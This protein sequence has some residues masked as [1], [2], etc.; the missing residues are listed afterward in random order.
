MN[1]SNIR[2][3]LLAYLEGELLPRYDA[4]DAAHRRDH[5]LAVAERSMNLAAH[6]DVDAEMVLTV[7][8]YHD[9]GLSEG[10]EHHH[11]V[12]AQLLLA[13]EHLR[14]WF[15]KEQLAVMAAAVADHRAS[16]AHAPRSIYGSIVAE[17][18]RL[19]DPLLVL[20]RTVQYGLAHYPHLEREQHYE[21]FL[22][23]LQEKYAEGGYLR[24]WLPQ[25]ANAAPLAELRRLIADNEQLRRQFESLY[26]AEA[27]K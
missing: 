15:S 6:Y 9:L 12:S 10:R 11:E 25:S 4:F 14:Q 5:A 18:D 16:A 7:A 8:Y 17:A 22:H 20:R 1:T 27:G 13:D 19:I 26:E 3:A 23:H 2:P 21:R 24:L